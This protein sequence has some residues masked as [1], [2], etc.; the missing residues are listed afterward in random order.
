MYIP[1]LTD[2]FIR[3]FKALSGNLKS[4]ATPVFQHCRNTNCKMIVCLQK[5]AAGLQILLQQWLMLDPFSLFCR[6]AP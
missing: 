2:T 6:T 5:K 3:G 1:G 4:A